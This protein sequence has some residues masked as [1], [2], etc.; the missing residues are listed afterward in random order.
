ME[1]RLT[2]PH[3][4][5]PG[6]TAWLKVQVGPLAPGQ[7]IRVTAS[8]GA[9]LGAVVPFGPGARRAGATYTVPVPTDAIHDAALM[10]EVMLIEAN[11]PPRDPTAAE[12]PSVTLVVLPGSP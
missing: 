3:P 5:A 11:R 4:L 2:L 12:V 10:V 7:R 8:G 6:E 1:R 9:V